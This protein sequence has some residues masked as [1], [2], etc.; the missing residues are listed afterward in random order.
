LEDLVATDAELPGFA[1]RGDIK[2]ARVAG[3]DGLRVEYVYKDQ[4]GTLFHVVAVAV[5][6][7]AA[8]ATYLITFDAP[9]ATF[10]RDSVVFTLMLE[11][12]KIV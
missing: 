3:H 11:S 7:K 5:S 8:G 9:E 10:A 12:F 6:D 1:P 2:A 4:D